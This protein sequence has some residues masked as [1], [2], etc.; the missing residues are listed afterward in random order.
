ME[1]NHRFILAVLNLV[2]E[3]DYIKKRKHLRVIGN[4][5]RL[6]AFCY[7]FDKYAYLHIGRSVT[8]TKYSIVDGMPYSEDINNVIRGEINLTGNIY[9]YWVDGSLS[10]WDRKMVIQLYKYYCNID[11]EKLIAALPEVK[12]KVGEITI[13]SM[14]NNRGISKLVSKKQVKLANKMWDDGEIW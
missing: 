2:C 13:K 14:L 1:N 4:N 12:G 11:I 7:L 5:Q 10:D 6:T 9:P 8:R 3:T